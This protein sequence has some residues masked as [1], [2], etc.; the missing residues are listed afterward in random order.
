MKR[1]FFLSLFLLCQSFVWAQNAPKF[2]LLRNATFLLE[3]NGTSFL[4][5]PMFAGKG[6]LKSVAGKVNSPLVDLTISSKEIL[7]RT[8]AVII[9]H[10]H[11]DHF[12][13]LAI[14]KLNKNLPLFNQ[15]FDK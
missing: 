2:Q 12:D 7:K 5:D 9:T 4:F 14:D 10:T 3:Y 6:E 13:D 1:I 11:F 15:P 8:D